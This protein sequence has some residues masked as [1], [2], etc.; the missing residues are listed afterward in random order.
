MKKSIPFVNFFQ[1][2][3]GG[4]SAAVTFHLKLLAVN[5]LKIVFIYK[6][7]ELFVAIRAY[8]ILGIYILVEV[9]NLAA[10]RTLD[11]IIFLVTVLTI[12]VAIAALVAILA[13]IALV[14]LIAVAVAI[15]F[16]VLTKVFLNLTEILI[17]FLNVLIKLVNSILKCFD[18]LCHYVNDVKKSRY[19][20]TLLGCL[21][22]L[23]SV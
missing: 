15:V 6:T 13:L 7:S 12:A 20:L 23:K 4:N 18:T 17:N 14:A 1:K 10:G 9:N 11:L 3:N 22:K 21:V 2:D 8:E 19:K 16:V 5:Y